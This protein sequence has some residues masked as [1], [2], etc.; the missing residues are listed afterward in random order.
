MLEWAEEDLVQE[1]EEVEDLKEMMRRKE[2][3]TT[4]HFVMLLLFACIIGLMLQNMGVL[5]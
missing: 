3:L 1:Q 4:Y 5:S 2:I